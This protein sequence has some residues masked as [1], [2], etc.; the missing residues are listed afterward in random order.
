MALFVKDDK[1]QKSD[2]GT[3][4]APPSTFPTAPSGKLDVQAHL[5]Q[6]SRVEGKLT[7]EGSVRIDGQVEG[8]IS[9]QDTVIIGDSAE[10]TA[11]IHANTV[12]VHGRVNGDI[13][14]RKR[15]ELNAPATVVGNI[16][17]PSLVIHEGVVFEGH[18]TMG[19]AAANRAERGDK[20]IA[21]FPAEERGAAGRRSSEA[22][23]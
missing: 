11:Q 5:G 3:P 14:A 10:L 12:V 17:T 9:A 2:D 18:C 15:V 21:L 22:A 20:R 16:S 13:T 4:L 19:G 7:F 8:E 23:G 6:G 1:T